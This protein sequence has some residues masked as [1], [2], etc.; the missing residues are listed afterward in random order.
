MA[1]AVAAATA[2][3]GEAFVAAPVARTGP[4]PPS[5][6]SWASCRAASRGGGRGAGVNMIV[7]AEAQVAETTNLLFAQMAGCTGLI[8]AGYKITWDKGE[9][10]EEGEDGEEKEVDIFRDTAL[11]YMGYANEVGEAFRPLIPA[12]AVVASYGVAIAYVSADAVAKGFKCAK[13]SDS[14]TCALPASFDVLTFQMLA[15]VVFPGFTINRW[16]AFVE[17]L[18]QASDLE[19][20]FPGVGGWLPT[21][22]GLGLIPFIVA[23]LDN[24]VEEVLD[25][26]IRPV[27][28]DKFPTCELEPIFGAEPLP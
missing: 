19:S 23:P 22:A 10:A 13:E 12:F 1:L 15:S 18:L 27:L 14:K 9:E 17:Y 8:S 20:Q 7:G 4:L 5:S 24:L 2:G 11:R 21:A 3:V 25:R 6:S 16:V 28:L 26:T